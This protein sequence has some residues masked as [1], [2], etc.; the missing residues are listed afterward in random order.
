MAK[1]TPYGHAYNAE[2]IIQTPGALAGL[3]AM[4][5][6]SKP[7]R[8]EA[9]TGL[10]CLAGTTPSIQTRIAD[11]PGVIEGLAELLRTEPY[12]CVAAVD[13]LANLA[14]GAPAIGDRIAQEPSVIT[15]IVA[16]LA[17]WDVVERPYS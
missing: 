14:A 8:H 11:E 10:A 6:G 9:A 16:R 7:Q 2:L 13:A 5:K 12:G 1:Q 4:L 17:I 3:V 15:G